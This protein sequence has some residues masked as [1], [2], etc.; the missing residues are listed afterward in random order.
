M[1]RGVEARYLFHFYSEVRRLPFPGLAWLDE[2]TEISSVQPGPLS[3][4]RV[5]GPPDQSRGFYIPHA[6]EYI[7]ACQI[8][9]SAAAAFHIPR[10]PLRESQVGLNRD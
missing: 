4:T 3:A 5:L 9:R 2:K 10:K 6:S 7:L 8:G 1:S